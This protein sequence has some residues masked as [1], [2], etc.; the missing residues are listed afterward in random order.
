MS[1]PVELGLIHSFILTV[2]PTI[3]LIIFVIGIFVRISSW[4]RGLPHFRPPLKPTAKDIYAIAKHLARKEIRSTWLLLWPLHI[5]F[6]FIFF[7][8]LRSIGVWRAEWFTWMASKGFLTKVLP[9]ILGFILLLSIL[10]FLLRRLI[11]T[12]MRFP[13]TRFGDYLFLFCIATIVATGMAMRLLPHRP[14]VL[15]FQLLP[16]ITMTIEEIPQLDILTIHA[17][18]SELL[19]MYIPFSRLMH[20][21]TGLTT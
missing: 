6:F 4:R 16:G 18:L 8:H 1:S 5:T 14:G 2:L 21:I 3:A 12:N 9:T 7:G 15:T 19:I 20:I 10:L 13:P 17:F 11:S